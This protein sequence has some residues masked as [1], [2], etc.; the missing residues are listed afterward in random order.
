MASKDTFA[1]VQAKVLDSQNI[2]SD[3]ADPFSRTK[4]RKIMLMT[5]HTSTVSSYNR[6]R[7]GFYL[8]NFVEKKP[9]SGRKVKFLFSPPIIMSIPA[10]KRIER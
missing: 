3:T 4:P 8:L 9:R 5:L 6:V 2:L 10:S 1:S 7:G